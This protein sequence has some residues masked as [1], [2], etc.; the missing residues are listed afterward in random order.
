MKE[1]PIIMVHM[2]GQKLKLERAKKGYTLEQ[3]AF[4]A[5]MSYVQISNIENNRIKRPH[6]G[7]LVRL[8]RALGLEANFFMEE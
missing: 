1:K 3:L 6:P 4:L 5:K 8:A 7:T 2:D